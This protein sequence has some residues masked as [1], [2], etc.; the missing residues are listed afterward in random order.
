MKKQTKVLIQRM[1]WILFVIYL[2][3]LVY[4]LFFSERYGRTITSQ[5]YKYN[6]VLFQ[7]IKRFIRY[8]HQLGWESFLVNIVG[9]VMAFTPFGFVLP[10]ISPNSRKFFN[11][12]LLSFEFTMTIELLQLL[13][14][15]GIFDVDDIFMNT[16]GGVIGYCCFAICHKIVK[17]N[18]N[19]RMVGKNG[20][21]K[22]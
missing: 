20:K 22:N 13:L 17:Y 2:V 21:I 11:I 19:V 8:R 5:N 1:A 6:L 16:L 7:E 3:I 4:F 10:I 15:V 18:H 9:N 12:L 14:K